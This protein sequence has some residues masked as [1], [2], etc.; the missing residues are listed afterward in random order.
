LWFS[1][2][3]GESVTGIMATMIDTPMPPDQPDEGLRQA[4]HDAALSGPMEPVGALN[5][6]ILKALATHLD[7]RRGE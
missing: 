3:G 1:S 4:F 6:Y 2:F 5:L 7:E